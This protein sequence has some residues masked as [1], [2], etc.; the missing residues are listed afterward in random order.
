MVRDGLARVRVVPGGDREGRRLDRLDVGRPGRPRRGGDRV[1]VEGERLGDRLEPGP[2]AVASSPGRSGA[3]AGAGCRRPG[4][5]SRSRRRAPRDSR[6]ATPRPC[7]RR[8]SRGS[9]RSRR[10]TGASCEAIES[11]VLPPY[12]MPQIARPA[13][14]PGLARDPR[15]RVVAVELLGRRERRRRD[16]LRFAVAAE[17][18]AEARVPAARQRDLADLDGAPP[19]HSILEVGRVLEQR[20]VATGRRRQVE[21]RR[22]VDPVAHG[23]PQVPLDPDVRHRPDLPPLTSLVR[24]SGSRGDYPTAGARRDRPRRRIHGTAWPARTPVQRS[25]ST[26]SWPLTTT[27][28]MPIGKR[29]GSS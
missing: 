22:Q 18:E 10:A 19:A 5:P 25:W 29:R 8:R 20:R 26:A 14:A 12:E 3:A 1:P 6:G 27:N 2:P 16:T 24:S 21:V 9:P 28:G 7:T 15:Q 4:I 13:G 23:N 17:V 11:A